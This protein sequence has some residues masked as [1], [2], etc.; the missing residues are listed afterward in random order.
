MRRR[1]H[2]LS[3]GHQRGVTQWL[4]GRGSLLV[5]QPVKNSVEMRIYLPGVR[6][7]TEECNIHVIMAGHHEI[8]SSY[9]LMLTIVKHRGVEMCWN[10]SWNL[11]R[12]RATGCHKL[13]AASTCQPHVTS[14]YWWY[15]QEVICVWQLGY[16]TGQNWPTC[17]DLCMFYSYSPER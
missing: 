9:S 12:L 7:G 2:L 16:K 17:G 3:P 1:I 6:Q 15:I 8:G 13:R 5:G 14:S 4:G 10:Q 11:M